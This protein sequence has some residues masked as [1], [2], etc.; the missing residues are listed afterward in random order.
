MTKYTPDQQ[1]QQML[2]LISRFQAKDTPA[3]IQRLGNV[4][5]FFGLSTTYAQIAEMRPQVL[6]RQDRFKRLT[7]SDQLRYMHQIY[8]WL[9]H[10]PQ[11]SATKEATEATK[12]K[13]QYIMMMF[14]LI[15]AFARRDLAVDYNED[16]DGNWF[17]WWT[18]MQYGKTPRTVQE[19]QLL[20]KLLLPSSTP[21]PNS[22][23]SPSGANTKLDISKSSS[24]RPWE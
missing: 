23:S 14:P 19:D 11:S 8:H 24:N 9:H 15:S 1:L 22:P 6:K 13:T 5:G 12:V 21:Q 2:A 17:L 20:Q 16:R 10:A 18:R 7:K 4:L 3:Q